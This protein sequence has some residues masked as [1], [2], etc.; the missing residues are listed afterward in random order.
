MVTPA[1]DSGVPAST[2]SPST[3]SSGPSSPTPSPPAPAPARRPTITDVARAAGVSIAV[4]S[5][6][7][8]GRPGVS[9][10]TR[11]RVLRVADEFGWR[12]SAAARSMRSGP[13]AIG[14]VVD[15]GAAGPVAQATG[16]LEFV[17]ALQEVLATR[18]LALMLQIVDGPEAAV[19][20][21]SDWW[22]E[23]RFDVMVVTDVLVEDPRIDALRRLRAPAVI[24]G[25]GHSDA[26][27]TSVTLDH[28][29]GF[30]RVG[31]YLLE[32]GHRHVALVSGPTELERTRER[33]AAL[34]GVLDAAGG[35]LVH[36]ATGGTAEEAAVAT[37]RLVTGGRAPTA[38]VYDSDQMAVAALDVARRTGL[39]VPWDLSVVAG[40][41]SALCRLA[42]PS[43]TTLPSA[44]RELGAATGEV[45]LAVLDGDPRA[46]RELH[47]GGLAVRGSTGPRSR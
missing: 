36:E 34:T 1:Y 9:A 20:L 29:E 18:N 8:N 45:V 30:V 22:A 14:L 6:A 11:E 3:P 2:A 43:I 37:R 16:V 27:V 41:D 40:S 33:L 10:A 5:Y 32:L 4:V 12:P 47:I 39:A 25:A 44:Q 17:I 26:D 13:R 31:R 42:T 38:I 21:Y 7:L 23:R 35:L 15:R 24:V 46:Q 19:S 28:T